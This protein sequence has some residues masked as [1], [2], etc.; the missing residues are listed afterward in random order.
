MNQFVVGEWLDKDEKKEKKTREK[1]L[2]QLPD[3][4]ITGRRE[5]SCEFSKNVFRR[6]STNKYRLK[7]SIS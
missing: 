1:E 5:T 7:P 6:L 4:M 3:K 2:N